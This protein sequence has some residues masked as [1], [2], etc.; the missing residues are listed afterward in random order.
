ML[1][2]GRI[3]DHWHTMTRTGKSARLS[4][5]LAEPFVEIHPLDAAALD[6]RDADLV[7]L[8]SPHGQAL[9]RALVTDRQQ[10]GSVFT[11]MHWTG[12]FANA[13][14]VDTLVAPV[15]DPV[16]GQPASKHVAVRARRYTAGVYGFLVSAEKPVGLD[17][18]YWA[19]AKAEGGWRTELALEA[20]AGD[21]EAW[22][23][24]R[25]AL[26]ETAE[27]I[28][29]SDARTGDA[30]LAIF[31]GDRLLL[32]LFIARQPVGVSRSFV[33]SQ[34]SETHADAR[35]RYAVIAGRPGAGRLDAGA[36]VCSCFSVGINQ[37]TAAVAQGCHTVEAIGQALSAGTNCGSCRAE[38]R[39]IIHASRPLAAE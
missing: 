37:I 21:W 30:R 2:T 39:G 31:D 38:I 28:G 12:E 9:L 15:T 5:H 26:P 35:T 8:E 25:V 23:R 6:I 36:T 29:Y 13:G 18:A 4:A 22:C 27:T 17:S 20:A 19:L 1:N 10:R 33:V 11:P 32:A 3:R 16:S 34:L 7:T 24:S 14:R